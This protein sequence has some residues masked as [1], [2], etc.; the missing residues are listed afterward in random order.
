M[1]VIIE[2]IYTGGDHH[3][4]TNFNFKCFMTLIFF[5]LYGWAFVIIFLFKDSLNKLN[6]IVQFLIIFFVVTIFEAL[7]GVVSTFVNGKQ[8]WKYTEGGAF[9]NGYVSIKTSIIF[10]VFLLVAKTIM[11]YL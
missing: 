1:G 8:N 7:A 2:L 11:N 9:F 4:L 10:S 5:N 3:F 6:I